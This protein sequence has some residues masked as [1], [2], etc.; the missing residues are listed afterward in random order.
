LQD[1]LLRSASSRLTVRSTGR[2]RSR[3]S[4]P[5]VKFQLTSSILA[6]HILRH[7]CE[8]IEQ[9]L[10][11]GLTVFKIGVSV[12]PVFR[13]S[14]KRYGYAH[15]RVDPFQCMIVLARLSTAEGAGLLEA[16]LIKAFGD[17]AG[18]RNTALGGEGVPGE[19]PYYVYL[20]HRK[21]PEPPLRITSA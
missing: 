14:N 7:C 21:L 10:R 17:R 8:A 20:V 15:D 4:D 1:E 11:Q 19:G 12:D 9:V 3:N 5:G 18:C 13:W 6:G 2:S 16:S